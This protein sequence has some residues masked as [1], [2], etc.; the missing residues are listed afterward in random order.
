MYTVI[1][2]HCFW[3]LVVHSSKKIDCHITPPISGD[4]Y[5]PTYISWWF[6][7]KEESR[8]LPSKSME[9]LVIEPETGGTLTK[10]F[11]DPWV[12][13]VVYTPQKTYWINC[14]CDCSMTQ[15]THILQ[16]VNNINVQT[17]PTSIH[18]NVCV[19]AVYMCARVYIYFLCSLYP[20]VS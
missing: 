3:F 6:G 19:Y 11:F 7:G 2:K 4:S 10:D 8:L 15:C 12:F 20:K 1:T 18:M 16:C 14:F 17:P 9:N 13:S 5:H